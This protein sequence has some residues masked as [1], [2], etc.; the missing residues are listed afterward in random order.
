MDAGA[1]SDGSHA[2]VHVPILEHFEN[3][4]CDRLTYPF[5]APARAHVPAGLAITRSFVARCRTRFRSVQCERTGRCR[6]RP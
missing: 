3:R 4:L 2:E 1:V 6:N 5:G